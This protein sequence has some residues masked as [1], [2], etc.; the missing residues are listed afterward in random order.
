MAAWWNPMEGAKKKGKPKKKAE[1]GTKRKGVSA[2]GKAA[3]AGAKRKPAA[4]AV[5]KKKTAAG[6][7]AAAGGPKRKGAKRLAAPKRKSAAPSADAPARSVAQERIQLRWIAQARSGDK[8]NIAN[9][10]LFAPTEEMYEIF[11]REVTAKRVKSHFRGFVRG[12]V[13]RYEVPN[14]RALNFVAHAALGGGAAASLRSDPLGKSYGSNLL[15]MEIEVPSDVLKRT[16]KW[17]PP[18]NLPDV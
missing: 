3:K 11:R 18:K 14:V 1:S 17:Q 16:P 12:R 2:R 7:K 15:R 4:R 13:D 6:V 5:T 8:G 10:A 9:I